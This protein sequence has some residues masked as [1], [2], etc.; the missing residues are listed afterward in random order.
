MKFHP[1]SKYSYIGFEK[2]V[3]KTKKEKTYNS[4]LDSILFKS[5]ACTIQQNQIYDYKENWKFNFNVKVPNPTKDRIKK[6]KKQKQKH[7]YS[8]W[9]PSIQ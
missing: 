2:N 9:L 3:M 1:W 4:N 7:F 6:K 8:I 5:I